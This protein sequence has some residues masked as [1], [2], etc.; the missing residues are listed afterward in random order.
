MRV[1]DLS[2]KWDAIEEKE[3]GK[4]IVRIF[5][6]RSG[7]EE[8]DKTKKIK[9]KK[10]SHEPRVISSFMARYRS[11]CSHIYRMTP[12]LKIKKKI[13]GLLENFLM[14]KKKSSNFK[15]SYL[16]K[17]ASDDHVSWIIDF[18]SSD[19]FIWHVI[20]DNEKISKFL[21]S[22]SQAR[23][24]WIRREDL[25]N[26]ISQELRV[27]ESDATHNHLVDSHLCW[28]TLN[29]ERSKDWKFFLTFLFHVRPKENFHSNFEKFY[30]EKYSQY[31]CANGT[32]DG[33]ASFSFIPRRIWKKWNFEV[34]PPGG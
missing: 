33:D 19:S 21:S 16:E 18:M 14:K 13:S 32:I 29:L 5:F 6:V 24:E 25:K 2:L 8:G 10:L 11:S 12:N 15:K 28:M 23:F 4:K 9:K 7:S 34:F 17:Y 3:N 20:L 22:I 26:E 27:I 30:L 1:E 31:S